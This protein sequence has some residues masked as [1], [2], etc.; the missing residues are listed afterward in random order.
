MSSREKILDA[1]EA[2]LIEEGERAASMNAIA[3]RAGVSK[4]GLLYHFPDKSAL[5]DGLLERA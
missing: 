4:G 2:L 1:Y 5:I 3:S